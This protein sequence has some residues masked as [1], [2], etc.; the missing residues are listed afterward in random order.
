MEEV[1]S[2]FSRMKK[3]AIAQIAFEFLSIVFAVLLAL[4][5]N[6]YK[7]NADLKSESQ[8]LESNILDECQ[9]NL[10]KLDSSIY[11]NEIYQ[12]YLDSLLSSDEIDGFEF[13]FQNKLLSSI[14]WNFTT[15]S[16]S[17]QFMNPDFLNDAA[18]IYENQDYYM[19]ISNQMFEHLGDMILQIDNTEA[20]TLTLT[21]DYYLSNLISASKELRSNYQRFLKKHSRK[22]PNTN[23]PQK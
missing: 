18:E 22:E 1:I 13:N 2:Y 12:A 8:L 5:L 23:L 14:A 11:E 19:K 6:S 7:Q 21:G 4:G 10:L 16:K 15:S 20:R 9:A 3:K 17:F